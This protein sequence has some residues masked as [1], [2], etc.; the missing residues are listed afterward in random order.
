MHTKIQKTRDARNVLIR[1]S[2]AKPKAKGFNILLIHI[3]SV[4]EQRKL[5]DLKVKRAKSFCIILI[6]Y[7]FLKK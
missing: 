1:T 6:I 3:P 7:H 5:L 4:W 2:L